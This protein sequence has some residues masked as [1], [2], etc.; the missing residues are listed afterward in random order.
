MKRFLTL[1]LFGFALNA[2][3]M[4]ILAQSGMPDS[5]SLV[6][7]DLTA[8]RHVFIAYMIA[9]AIILGWAISIGRRLGKIQRAW[10]D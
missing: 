6:S 7:Q 4:A 9:W 10:E 2:V 5:Q 1:F 3:P 8:Y